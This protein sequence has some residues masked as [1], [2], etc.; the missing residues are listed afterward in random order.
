MTRIIPF[1]FIFTILQ[2]SQAYAQGCSDSGFCTMG[3]FK[4]DQP[5]LKKFN[6]RLNSI[7]LTQHLGHTKYGDWIHAT[8]LDATVNFFERTS[9]QVRLPAYTIVEGNM[10]TTRGWGDLFFNVTHAV[11]IKDNY[12]LNL[13][14]GAKIY[15]S[16]P[17]K[18]SEEGNPMP[19]YQQT[20]YGSNDLSV[21]GSLVTQKWIFA[22][23]YQHALNQTVNAFTHE[24]WAGNNLENVVIV[25]DPSAGLKRGD[26]IMVRVER[27]FRL[28]RFNF[29]AGALGLWRITPD[30]TLNQ[31]GELSNVPGSTG[32]AL[33]VVSGAGYQ[34]NRHMGV[35]L[36]LAV[37]VKERE[38]NPDGLS[39]DFVSQVAYI[40]R[41]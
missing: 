37:K 35:R 11:L 2:V 32:L 40:V 14:A 29:Y 17:I 34:F 27:N 21:G 41:F 33:N 26:D 6:I 12:T 19:F 30:R 15:T 16:L 8:F 25:Y 22:L 7:E 5:Y 4:P 24:A 28:S 23:G 20:T 31:L 38:A 10:P 36:L 13:T 39:R 1:L 9:L 18:A 3:A